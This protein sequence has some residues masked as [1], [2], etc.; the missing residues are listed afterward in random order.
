MYH[1]WYNAQDMLTRLPFSF[2]GV[3]LMD[4]F[5]CSWLAPSFRM[6]RTYPHLHAHACSHYYVRVV[7]QLRK[8]ALREWFLLTWPLRVEVARHFCPV[9]KGLL[10]PS[11]VLIPLV[12]KHLS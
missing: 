6:L 1:P 10:V 4:D 9:L 2:L 7:G 12:P 8:M 5:A 11:C 3:G